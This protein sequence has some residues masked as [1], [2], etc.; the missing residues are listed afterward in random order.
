M[1]TKTQDN[2]KP[3]LSPDQKA[4]LAKG[5]LDPSTFSALMLRDCSG[6]QAS[7]NA[8][9]DALA[10][11]LTELS[12]AVHNG[13]TRHIQSLLLSQ[14]VVL[15]M[16]FGTL[17]HRVLGS[18]SGGFSPNTMRVALKS[19]QQSYR[20]LAVL[21]A[22]HQ[23]KAATLIQNNSAQQQIVNNGTNGTASALPPSSENQANELLTMDNSNGS[24]L[25]GGRPFA[26]SASHP[27]MAAVDA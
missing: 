25:D 9:F 15:D 7:E 18:S 26:A 10:D 21:A 27:V 12:T 3:P 19:Q 1:T 16:I 8:G 14:A 6:W 2:E 4:E 5:V 20:T 11:R 23:P 24:T 13:D 17:L 22:M